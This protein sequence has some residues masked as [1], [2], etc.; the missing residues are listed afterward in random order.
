MGC[1]NFW[2]WECIWSYVSRF[3]CS[4][5]GNQFSLKW[6]LFARPYI[7]WFL[8]FFWISVCGVV[9]FYS[10]LVAFM[11]CLDWQEQLPHHLMS[12]VEELDGRELVF[13]WMDSLAPSLVQLL[14]RKCKNMITS[15]K[16]GIWRTWIWL[17]LRT[18][19][20]FVVDFQSHFVVLFCSENI[21]L[22]GL[23]RV[24]SRRVIQI[25]AFFMLFFSIF[26]EY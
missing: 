16:R 22:V 2:C 15:Y 19:E 26:G 23:T 7:L 24:G 17:S 12:S 5:W 10:Q 3:F 18:N 6:V 9:P 13:C 25:S 21:G 8:F 11:L 1:S 20:V 4:C 14:L